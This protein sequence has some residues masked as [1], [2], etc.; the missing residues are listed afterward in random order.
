M[1]NKDINLRKCVVCNERK[2]KDFLVKV[3]K[4]KENEVKIDHSKKL[5]GRGAYICNDKLCI[6]KAIENRSLNKAL[7]TNVSKEI[8]EELDAM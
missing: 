6:K 5:N 7:R 3:I 1:K 8:Y 2:H 4:T